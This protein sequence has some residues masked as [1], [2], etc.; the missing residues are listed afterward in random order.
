[1]NGNYGLFPSSYVRLR[2]EYQNNTSPAK[3][4]Q[5][6]LPSRP[7]PDPKGKIMLKEKKKA[8]K[9][10][11]STM[12]RNKKRQSS[13]EEK[14]EKDKLRLKEDAKEKEKEIKESNN[15]STMAIAVCDYCATQDDEISLKKGQLV[16]IIGRASAAWWSGKCLETGKIGFFPFGAVSLKTDSGGDRSSIKIATEE[17]EKRKQQLREQ[18][19]ERRVEE[20]IKKS[21]SIDRLAINATDYC[22]SMAFDVESDDE[23]NVQTLVNKKP[24]K[25]PK[26]EK[27]KSKTKKTIKIKN[28]KRQ[29]ELILT[30][31]PKLATM[32]SRKSTSFTYFS[33][34]MDSMEG[35]IGDLG[36]EQ[37][38]RASIAHSPGAGPS[39]GVYHKE[40]ERPQGIQREEQVKVNSNNIETEHDVKKSRTESLFPTIPLREEGTRP[41]SFTV[42]DSKRIPA[43]NDKKTKNKTTKPKA[44]T[45][46]GMLKHLPTGSKEKREEKEKAKRGKE[47]KKEDQPSSAAIHH[48][49]QQQQQQQQETENE[50]LACGGCGAT[51]AGDQIFCGQCGGIL[52]LPDASLLI[53]QHSCDHNAHAIKGATVTADGH[54]NSPPPPP[55]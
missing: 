44:G 47:A 43:D 27:G 8:R 55:Q 51:G 20:I 49:Q 30:K 16:T 36:S 19:R 5:A 21:T 32:R 52:Q 38:P 9:K 22:V 48:L 7:G 39:L 45:L 35:E 26:K 24:K 1:M 29:S 25:S 33:E 11:G 6:Q 17:K 53:N 40:T 4:T 50:E 13:S 54:N 23:C 10:S 31:E 28:P 37:V 3:P 41:V 15:K 2:E 42:N 46:R 12:K 34:R 14:E 18:R